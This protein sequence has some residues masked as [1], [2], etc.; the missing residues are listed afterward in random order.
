[1]KI[2]QIIFLSIVSLSITFGQ[3]IK[4]EATSFNEAITTAKAENK[5]IFVD[6]YTT[7][8]G[9]C[10]WMA[11]NVFTDPQVGDFYN[12]SFVN[13]K[14]DMEKGEGPRLA[15]SWEITGY[16]TLIFID[17]N[18]MVIHR[19]MGSRPAEDFVDLG[20]AANDPERQITTM[21]KRF[22]AGERNE[23][24][25]WKYTD[26]MTS[27]GLKGF[28][29]VAQMYMDTQ[30]DWT[31]EKN[32]KFLFDYADATM[33]SKLFKYTLDHREAFETLVGKEQ[34]GQKLSYAADIDR[35]KNGIARDNTEGLKTHYAK[36]YDDKTA[37]NKAMISYFN[38]LMYSSDPVEQ[39]K[40]KA[41][42]Q[43]FLAGKPDLG[44]S[45]Y[46]SAAWQV[47]EITTDQNL[48]KKASEWTDISINDTKNSFNTDTQAHILYK[49]GN[50]KEAR[51]YALSSIEIAKEEG[52]D[53]SATESLLE[54][55][56]K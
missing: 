33:D 5:L 39:E 54:E 44:W 11:K 26:A 15:K 42:I 52:A 20:H 56:E 45:F 47:F 51:R 30:S 48:L 46:N 19:S 35:S 17:K 8:C 14:I 38:Q 43:L 53:Y 10:K 3:G 31:T 41:E 28:E 29:E 32:M 40:F 27:A 36:Y 18:G 34:F 13:V 12:E 9:P 6:A 24:F 1:M 55:I 16:P 2:F 22:E 7:W 37:E 23:D 25:L 4:F 50:L 49:L 21:T